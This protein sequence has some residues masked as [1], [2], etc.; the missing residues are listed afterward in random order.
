MTGSETHWAHPEAEQSYNSIDQLTSIDSLL[1]VGPLQH[2]RSPIISIS[3]KPVSS[4]QKENISFSPM[5]S[6]PGKRPNII[7]GK[8]EIRVDSTNV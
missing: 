6:Y 4:S 1:T 5:H 7:L 3:S 2:F 8:A